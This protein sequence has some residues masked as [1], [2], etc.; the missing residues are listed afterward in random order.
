LAIVKR[1]KKI[2]KKE[3]KKE[4]REKGVGRG[5]VDQNVD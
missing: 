2:R 4:K 1:K 3:R 5:A